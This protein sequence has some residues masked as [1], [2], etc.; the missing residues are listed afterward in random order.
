M[1][2]IAPH[3]VPCDSAERITRVAVQIRD[4]KLLWSVS[5]RWSAGEP[6]RLGA[7]SATGSAAVT[8]PASKVLSVDVT[9]T[10]RTPGALEFTVNE[11]PEHASLWDRGPGGSASPYAKISRNE[12]GC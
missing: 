5:G 12:R 2:G 1:D 7:P 9:T 8:F 10:E 11:I 6:I 3:F 4:G